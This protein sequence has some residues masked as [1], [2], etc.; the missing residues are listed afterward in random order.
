MASVNMVIHMM[1]VPVSIALLSTCGSHGRPR[2]NGQYQ[3]NCSIKLHRAAA[4]DN[5][6]AI[7]VTRRLDKFKGMVL[8]SSFGN[9][10]LTPDV[11]GNHIFSG[12]KVA[13]RGTV[14]RRRHDLNIDLLRPAGQASAEMA[15]H[16]LRMLRPEHKRAPGDQPING[17]ISYQPPPEL[18]LPWALRGVNLSNS[19]NYS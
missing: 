13:Q 12:R 2:P 9:G 15:N 16:A 3:A 11:H 10:V 5:F 1:R 17:S 18:L 4:S 14:L 6:G 8:S 7:G 19:K